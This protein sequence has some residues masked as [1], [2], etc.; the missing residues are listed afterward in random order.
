MGETATDFQTFWNEGCCLP[1]DDPRYEIYRRWVT[2]KGMS[3]GDV[4]YIEF[5]CRVLKFGDATV[6]R[7][8]PQPKRPQS[9]DNFMGAEGEAVCNFV[10]NQVL[11]ELKKGFR[12]PELA[13]LFNW[14]AEIIGLLVKVGML[15]FSVLRSESRSQ[16]TA[17]PP[18]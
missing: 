12:R 1:P 18:L 6:P 5:L 4:C 11:Q 8:K 3:L 7:K 14:P 2:T 13:D 10:V 16:H 17:A 9:L 15:R